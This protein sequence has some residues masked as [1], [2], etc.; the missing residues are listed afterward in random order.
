MKKL[1]LKNRLEIVSLLL[2]VVV[3]LIAKSKLSNSQTRYY[4]LTKTACNSIC[5][6]TVLKK[7]V[8]ILNIIK[9]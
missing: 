8:S 7:N 2:V 1:F 9:K 4:T 3:L 5:N 6:V